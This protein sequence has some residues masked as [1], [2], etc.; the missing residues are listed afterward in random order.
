[1]SFYTGGWI[2][3]AIS[4]DDGTNFAY[5]YTKL[6][7]G[8]PLWQAYQNN[9]DYY[10]VSEKLWNNKFSTMAERDDLFRKA[11]TLAMEDGNRV[12]LID[13]VSFSPYSAKVQVAYDLA[14]GIS[15]TPLWPLTVQIKG[16]EG[17][18]V[19]VAQPGIMV[20]PWNAVAGSNWIYDRMP[21][22]ATN[23]VAT[24]PDPYTGLA[25]P[26][27]IEKA[28]ITVQTGTPVT[29]TLDWVTLNTADSIVPPDD[30][31]VDWD[32]TN[33]KWLTVADAK[34]A[35]TTVQGYKDTLTTAVG[36]L[37]LTKFDVAAMTTLVTD[38]GKAAGI[39]AATAA[40]TEENVKAFTDKVAEVAALK[41]DDE[42]KTAIVDAAFSF[43]SGLDTTG[44]FQLASYDFSSAKTKRV[45]TYP[46]D[47]WKTMKWHDGSPMSM[48]DFMLAMILN[49]DRAK[50]RQPAL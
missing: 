45:V 8:S 14:G 43:V 9:P 27:R 48:G 39:D 6:G 2:T 34:A 33:Q 30:A 22:N 1:M 38:L 15:G 17:G 4:R 25:W 13:Q 41:T 20:E 12:W 50:T 10:D 42:K 18:T 19:K 3:T 40:A 37:D 23:D 29:K 5:F 36:A 16:Q 46:S 11:M 32:A 24:M 7:S 44:T 47:L 28:E 31:W 26:Q 35:K 49:W 21:Q